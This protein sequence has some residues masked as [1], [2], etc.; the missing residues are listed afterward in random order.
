MHDAHTM[1]DVSRDHV[2]APSM[3]S[4]GGLAAPTR[5]C[6]GLGMSALSHHTP[7]GRVRE[8]HWGLPEFRLMY[9]QISFRVSTESTRKFRHYFDRYWTVI[10]DFGKCLVKDSP[11]ARVE[12]ER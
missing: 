7:N 5:P 12:M 8:A 1:H 9:W 2:G 3:T 10:S 4:E 11:P 6:W